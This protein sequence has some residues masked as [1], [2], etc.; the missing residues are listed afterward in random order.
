MQQNIN[1]VSFQA[2]ILLKK[3]NTEIKS[4]FVVGG[5]RGS[6]KKDSLSF[7]HKTS[8]PNRLQKLLFGIIKHTKMPSNG[9]R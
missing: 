7:F 5:S 1:N 2:R 6:I 4:Y 9:G 3:P 8:E